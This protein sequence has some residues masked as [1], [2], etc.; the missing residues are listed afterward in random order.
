MAVAAPHFTAVETIESRKESGK[1]VSALDG[2][3][4]IA[5]LLVMFFHL[6]APFAWLDPFRNIGWCGV[7]L[8]F[9]LSGYLITGILYSSVGRP[10]YFRNF[11]IR[12]TLRIFPVYYGYLALV[13]LVLRPVVNSYWLG[14]EGYKGALPF[15]LYYS[16]Y[17]D[18]F[19]GWAPIALA[20]FWSLAVEEHFYL[21]WPAFIRAV[22]RDKLVLWAGA[23][24]LV[25]PVSRLTTTALGWS[26]LASYYVTNARV[27]SLAIGAILAILVRQRPDL[28]R[29]WIPFISWSA[30]ALLAL[31]AVWR[32]GLTFSDWPMRTIGYSL[33]AL[34]FA[35]LV[36]LAGNT[37]GKVSQFLSNR[38]LIAFG[39][40]SYCLYVV[41]GLV[42]TVFERWFAPRFFPAMGWVEKAPLPLFV[43]VMTVSF[44]VAWLS[45]RFYESPILALKARFAA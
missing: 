7:D 37:D 23:I 26:W 40:Y 19:I 4:G 21:F 30:F 10:H 29:R 36:W 34:A 33:F 41:H 17:A 25:G 15:I 22:P 12:R 11:Y 45:W 32:H 14:L 13:L 24:A 3:R 44:S 5:I 18:V 42:Q 1:H 35:G 9:V 39:K 43:L 20:A 6:P 27:D 16:D 8:F 28:V 31:I 2:V 38:I